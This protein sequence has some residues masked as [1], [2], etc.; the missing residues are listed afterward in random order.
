[1]SQNNNGLW[2]EATRR[3]YILYGAPK[4]STSIIMGFADFGL[5]TLYALAYKIDP[6]LVAVGQGLGK[7][8]IAA[9]QFLLGW[10]SD[11]KYIIFLLMPGLLIDITDLSMVYIWFLIWYQI[12]NISYALTTPFSAWLVEQFKSK[13]RPKAS[14]YENTFGFFGT[15]VMAVFSMVVLSD[16]KDKIQA[17]PSVIPAEY[18]I[19]VI[20]FGILPLILYYLAFFLM[21]TEPHFKIESNLIENLKI[22]LRNKNYI[23][24]NLMYGFASMGWTIVGSQIIASGIFVIGILFFLYMWRKLVLGKGKKKSLM[25]TFISATIFLPFTLLGFLPSEMLTIFGY[26]FVLGIG[27]CLAGW[28]ILPPVFFSDIAE[29]DEKQSGELRAGI[30][31]GFPSILLNIF[32]SIGLTIMGLLMMLPKITVGTNTFTMGYVLWGPMSSLIIFLAYLYA[33]KYIQLDFE[34]EEKRSRVK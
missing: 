3:K 2:T 4:L 22:I 12:F 10:I 23:R 6:T 25:Y 9:S 1:M 8:T 34:W 7:L 32:Q 20:I 11:A 15:A 30:Y 26:I 28:F 33:R 27:G 21:P 29:D 31:R 14:Q 24:V 16:F 19:S 17:N 13:D 18:F 5:F